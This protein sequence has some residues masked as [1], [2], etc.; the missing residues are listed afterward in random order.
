VIPLRDQ[1]YI[2]RL[3]EQELE[4]RVKIDYF[5]QR[6]S[7]LIVP[8]REECAACEDTGKL[9]SELAALSEK[10]TLTVYELAEAPDDAKKLK[11]DK[12]P[13]IVVRGPSNRGL[14]F[15]GAPAGNEFPNF[16]ETIVA[17]SKQKVD[18]GAESAKHLRKLKDKVSVAVY[19]T[20]T[21]P[22]CPQMVRSAYRLALASAH[23]DAT[24]IEINE[25][26]RLAQ[27]LGV[28]SVPLTVLNGEKAIAGV[29]DEATLVEAVLRVAEGRAA[30]AP[31]GAEATTVAV[32]AQAGVQP[33]APSGLILPR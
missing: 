18:I 23:V 24:A 21:C 16:V 33:T 31:G 30:D 10:I 2:R 26:P 1:E 13:G 29:M 12:V 8:G 17:A 25:F 28:R 27:Q 20:P 32:E 11:I 14:R 3:F 4:G 15:F 6:P 22:Y 9:L 5:T 7:K 19:V